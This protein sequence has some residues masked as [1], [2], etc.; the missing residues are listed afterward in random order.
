[1]LNSS[2]T[3]VARYSYDPNGVTTL[4]SGTDMATFGF[5][6]MQKDSESGLYLTLRRIYNAWLAIWYSRD[7]KS[8]GWDGL[9]AIT[10]RSEPSL[11]AHTAQAAPSPAPQAQYE[12]LYPTDDLRAIHSQASP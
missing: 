5:A 7:P 12:Y 11:A 10:H 1:M 9:Q 3:I 6:G 8:E 4:V 2:G